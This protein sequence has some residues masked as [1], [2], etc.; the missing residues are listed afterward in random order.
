MNSKVAA[1]GA[2]N[3]KLAKSGELVSAEGKEVAPSY[4]RDSGKG[5]GSENITS[6]DLIIPRVE[7]AQAQSKCLS[8]KDPGYIEGISAGD[9]YNTVTRRN[10]GTNVVFVPI[11]FNREYLLWKDRS[12]G[13]GGF[14]GHFPTELE[15]IQHKRTLDDADVVTCQE[16]HQQFGLVLNSDGSMDEVFVSMARTKLKASRSFNSLARMNGGDRF[17]RQYLLTTVE[18]SN[19]K[20]DFWNY[21]FANHGY[22]KEAAYT[23]ANRLYEQIMSGQAK[24]DRTF[25]EEVVEERG[26][27]M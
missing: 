3:N 23:K 10:Y 26:G 22:P 8:K 20:G 9:L 13:G 12:E 15:A 4:I 27:E 18:E 16:T 21:A 19:D 6:S 1:K 5:L 2:V 7:V 25:D 11:Y 24:A 14:R 17:G